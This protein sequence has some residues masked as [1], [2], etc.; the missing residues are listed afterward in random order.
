MVDAP[1]LGSSS[2]PLLGGSALGLPAS[3]SGEPIA[4]SRL[5][6]DRID[7]V[8]ANATPFYQTGVDMGLS[9]QVCRFLIFSSRTLYSLSAHHAGY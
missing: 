3:G 8:R 1:V 7:A 5:N 2:S 4:L 6:Y 9:A